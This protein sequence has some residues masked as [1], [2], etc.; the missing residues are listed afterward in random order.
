[1]PAEKAR[2]LSAEQS[3]Q[4]RHIA[5][6]G[7]LGRVG[8]TKDQQPGPAV[9]NRDQ[10]WKA[11]DAQRRSLAD[12]L[13]D[14]SADAWRQ[15]SLYGGWT[16]RGVAAHLTLQQLGLADM[17]ATMVKSAA[18]STGRSRLRLPARGGPVHRADHRPRFA[19]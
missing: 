7:F 18:T 5:S 1:L 14:L 13:D 16:V 9:L 2:S 15:P 12:L 10:V 4:P 8:M 19:A 11:I 3:A 17:L 6:N